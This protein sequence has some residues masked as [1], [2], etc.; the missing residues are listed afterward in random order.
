MYAFVPVLGA[1]SEHQEPHPPE[2]V[3]ALA[4]VELEDH[5]GAALRFGDF[6]TDRPA[7][8]VFLRHYG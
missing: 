3:D 1:A 2:R 8:L 5:T 6:W 4:D 7:V